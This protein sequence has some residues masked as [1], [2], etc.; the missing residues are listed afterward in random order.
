MID[1]SLPPGISRGGTASE[2]QN[3][4]YNANLM[5]W[6]DGR[7]EPIG[8]WS[9][10]TRSAVPSPVRRIFPWRDNSQLARVVLGMD[11]G[12]ALMDGD[13]VVDVTPSGF[14][15]A[16]D[17]GGLPRGYGV[18]NYGEEDYGTPRTE[19]TA[20]FLRAPLWSIDNFGED[21]L[22]LS[23]TDGKLYR[24]S[25][26][27][28][29]DLKFQQVIEAG[30]ANGAMLV[31]PERHVVIVGFQGDARRVAWCSQ[32][33]F[34]DWDITSTTNTAGDLPINTDGLL[35]SI[36]PVRDGSLIFSDMEVFLLRYVGV[37][38]VYGQTRV[39][40]EVSLLTPNSVA[41]FSGMAAWM[42]KSS[43]FIYRGGGAVETLPC[44]IGDLFPSMDPVYGILRAHA[45][46]HGSASEVWWAYPT[47]GNTECNKIAVWNYAENWWTT[48]DI[49]RTAM[50]PAGVFPNPLAAGVDRMIYQHEDGTTNSGVSRA[51]GSVFLE[52][53]SVALGNGST[54]MDILGGQLDTNGKTTATAIELLGRFARDAPSVVTQT[55]R[56]K[57]NGEIDLRFTGR[58]VRFRIFNQNGDMDWSVGKLR[59][60]ARPG[61]GR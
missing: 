53:A 60:D 52:S 40:S 35:Q 11:G 42:G 9:R 24:W 27:F 45:S 17:E 13:S 48:H 14:I 38:F 2:R 30:E 34:T 41:A 55:A 32:E 25:P 31:T 59:F 61:S 49:P 28:T 12:L 8:G 22:A 50:A 43:F 10:A 54:T 5:R 20:A 19:G 6:R 4:W 7:A 18:G 26:T 58:D 16:T 3:R 39:G 51:A 57:A 44:D 21:I 29:G 15:T 36:V 33:N 56:P 46:V 47:I 37:P 1:V 23:S